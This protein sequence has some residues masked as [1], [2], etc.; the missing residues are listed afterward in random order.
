VDTQ[1]K[2]GELRM[3]IEKIRP[4]DFPADERIRSDELTAVRAL[5]PGE[6]VK[7]PC[8][9]PHHKNV[10]MGLPGIYTTGRRH[11]FRVSIRCRD[12]MVYV[13]RKEEN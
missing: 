9:W 7:F 1:N 2:K 5:Q 6:A 3:A 8:R 10:C 13:M 4:E 12:K 11:G